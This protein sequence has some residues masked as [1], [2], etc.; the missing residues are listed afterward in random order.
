MPEPTPAPAPAAAPR[1]HVLEALLLAVAFAVAHTQS[2]LYYSN[3]NQYFVHGLANGG[4]VNLSHDWL[5]GTTDPTPVFTALVAFGYKHLGEWSFQAA[6]FALLAGYFLSVR[7]L[8]AALPGVPDTRAFRL[9]WAAGFVAAHAAVLRVLSVKLWGVDYP[10]FLQAGVAGQY[11][12][13]PGLQP[14]AFGVLLVAGLAAFAHRRSTLACGLV[15]AAC[16]FHSTY[17]LAAGSLVLGFLVVLFREDDDAGPLALRGLVLASLVVAPVAAFTLFT[18]GPHDPRTFET[19]QHILADVRI[20]H[21]CNIDRWLDGVAVAQLA[22]AAAGV[23][24]LRRSRIFVPLAIAALIGF[25]LTLA[26][27]E[28]EVTTLALAFPWRITVV[29]VPLATA[30]ILARTA[31]LLPDASWVAWVGAAVVV[32]LAGAGAWVTVTRQGYRA[33]E[34]EAPLYDFVRAHSGPTQVYLLPVRI[35]AV[36]GGRGAM[37]AS[38]TPPPRPKP[39]SNLIPVDL[40]RFR[41][42][43]GTPIYVDFKSVPYFETEVLEWLRRMQQC[44]E[45]YAGDWS[46]PGRLQKL[47]A[48]KITHVVTPADKPLTA[49]YLEEV[50][51]D[52]AYI[53]YRLR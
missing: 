24:L 42:H 8:V 43:T 50:H 41:L 28:Y 45:W 25:G 22:W 26:Q 30:A 40:Q 47:R 53:V 19:A 29:L 4:H 31:S 11:V 34:D 36:G 37:S 46:A 3:Q 13:G 33:G 18:F 7:W 48:E 49:E 1:S 52:P 20:P 44:E 35:P 32:A 12:L 15:A 9:I 27:Y 5:A 21:H 16:A 14:S 17:V 6:Y 39:G 2:P 38:F 23:V 10:W 51:A